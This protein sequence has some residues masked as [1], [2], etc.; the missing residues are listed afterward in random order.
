[1]KMSSVIKIISTGAVLAIAGCDARF[2]AYQP[3][4]FQ[5]IDPTTNPTVIGP[6][7]RPYDINLQQP[8]QLDCFVESARRQSLVNPQKDLTERRPKPSALERN[9]VAR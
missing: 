7:C 8:A 3:T 5:V 1:M 9:K 4:D 6:A 2:A